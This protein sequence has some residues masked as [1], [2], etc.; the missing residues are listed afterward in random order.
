MNVDL[1]SSLQITMVVLVQH[2]Q[3]KGN[4]LPI[5][6]LN[7]I[8]WFWFLV[9]RAD[10]RS[11]WWPVTVMVSWWD[12][13]RSRR[14]ITI[15]YDY[16]CWCCL[17]WWFG[18]FV[19]WPRWVI[20]PIQ[21]QSVEKKGLWLEDESKKQKDDLEDLKNKNKNSISSFADFILKVNIFCLLHIYY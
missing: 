20:W 6:I 8:S 2:L 5:S 14:S 12:D 7:L 15:L 11:G 13:W 21:S 17:I 18:L 10:N 4:F 16:W 19:N 1:A 9:R 3:L